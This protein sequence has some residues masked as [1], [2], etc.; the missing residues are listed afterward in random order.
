MVQP[1]TVIRTKDAQSFYLSITGMAS[2]LFQGF[3]SFHDFMLFISDHILALG[4]FSW[5]VGPQPADWNH[6]GT[7]IGAALGHMDQV[8]KAHGMVLPWVAQVIPA[9]PPASR[10]C[11]G[12]V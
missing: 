4:A 10:E 7:V 6:V 3:Q 11:T 8:L 5:A 1:F 2:F 9:C 12:I